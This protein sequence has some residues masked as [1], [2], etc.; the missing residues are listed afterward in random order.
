MVSQVTTTAITEIKQLIREFDE[1]TLI[2]LIDVKKLVYF[3]I[4]THAHQRLNKFP[5]LRFYGP[6]ESGKSD[7]CHML[8]DLCRSPAIFEDI[9]AWTDPTI[10]K[11]LQNA[12]AERGTCI[13]DEADN[14]PN[15]LYEAVFEK[16][17]SIVKKMERQGANWVAVPMDV[18]A[19]LVLNGRRDLGDASRQNRTIEITT[20]HHISGAPSGYVEESFEKYRVHCYVIAQSINWNEVDTNQGQRF[21]QKWAPLKA[22]ASYLGDEDFLVYLDEEFEESRRRR[23][24]ERSEEIV[25]QTIAAIIKLCYESKDFPN[26]LRLSAIQNE[27]EQFTIR[28]VGKT[29]V[30]LG[31]DKHVSG[32][33]WVRHL[34]PKKLKAIADENGYQD[35]WLDNLASDA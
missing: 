1:I 20:R 3:A 30:M 4:S 29:V 8:K 6:T 24:E 32:V 23:A 10:K 11:E 16:A 12:N 28:E 9:K 14:F 22:V 7:L 25:P 31:L 34:T 19:P 21:L 17:N 15:N 33:T 18:W 35:D 13:L 5:L 27:I 26:K 2:P